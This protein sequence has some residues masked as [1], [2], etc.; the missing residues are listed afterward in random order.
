[1][2]MQLN[3]HL[4]LSNLANSEREKLLLTPSTFAQGP[5]TNAYK[6]FVHDAMI[7]QYIR[8]LNAREFAPRLCEVADMADVSLVAIRL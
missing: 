4:Q 3:L 7:V 5:S 6:E 2:K 8:D 1:M